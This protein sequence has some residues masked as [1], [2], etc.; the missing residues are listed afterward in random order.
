MRR[1]I[2]A[3]LALALATLQFAPASADVTVQRTI[4]IST[5][6]QEAP[7]GGIGCAD[8]S[9]PHCYK[10]GVVARHARCHYLLDPASAQDSTTGKLGYVVSIASTSRSKPFTL[11]DISGLAAAMDFDIQFYE[12]LGTCEGEPLGVPAIAIETTPPFTHFGNEAGTV[13]AKAAYA[14][15][16]LFGGAN[17]KFRFFI[18]T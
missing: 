1:T 5:V 18:N 8:F 12:T 15:I 16:T 3:G 11:T 2:L 13:P 10:Q 9:N 4:Q 14:I 6:F 17:A 7:N